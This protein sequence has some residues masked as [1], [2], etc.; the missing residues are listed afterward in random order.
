MAFARTAPVSLPKSV[1]SIYACTLSAVIL[2]LSKYECPAQTANQMPTRDATAQ[3]R[4][5]CRGLN[6]TDINSLIASAATKKQPK[7]PG[8]R[9]VWGIGNTAQVV[10]QR[11]F[12]Y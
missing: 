12:R 5:L 2:R 9:P 6:M 10:V 11:W 4:N 3:A 8:R 7:P 1:D